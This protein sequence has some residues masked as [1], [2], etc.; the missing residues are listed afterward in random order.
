MFTLHCW[1]TRGLALVL[2]AAACSTDQ[3]NPTQEGDV[4]PAETAAV[5]DA[6][7][8]AQVELSS[9]RG[10]RIRIYQAS[11]ATRFAITEFVP[12]LGPDGNPVLGAD[13]RPIPARF[14]VE[15]TGPCRLRHFGEAW[16]T[17]TQ[18]VVFNADGSQKL[19]G[20]FQYTVADGDVLY[21]DFEGTGALSP[22]DPTTTTFEGWERFTGGTGR[23]SGARGGARAGGSANLASGQ[24]VFQSLGVIGY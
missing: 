14:T 13:G 1:H 24:S 5:A 2:L 18:H 8:G 9:L 23:L 6:A 16:L 11:C 19:D 10:L 7:S 3:S 17:A 4:D 12:V 21:T 15:I 20:K 22:S